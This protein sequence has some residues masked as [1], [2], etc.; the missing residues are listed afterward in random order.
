MIYYSKHFKLIFIKL[1][2]RKQLWIFKPLCSNHK[3]VFLI[4]ILLEFHLHYAQRNQI[5]IFWNLWIQAFLNFR[6]FDFRN[7]QFNV[8]YDSIL[9]FYPLVLLSNLDLWGFRFRLFFC[10][11]IL[12]LKQRNSRNACIVQEKQLL[13]KLF[14]NHCLSNSENYHLFDGRCI[15]FET[16]KFDYENAQQNCATK[17]ESF[18]NVKYGS[19]IITS[20]VPSKILINENKNLVFP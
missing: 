9:F 15:Y 6:G 2:T 18:Y 10:P 8:V 16:R 17:A 3:S 12:M 14:E 20:K 19:S 1:K 13:P 4:V 5:R 7:F 11:H